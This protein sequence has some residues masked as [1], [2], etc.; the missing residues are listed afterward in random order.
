[1]ENGLSLPFVLHHSLCPIITVRLPARMHV[2][3]IYI[4]HG[5]PELHSQLTKA[6][7]SDFADILCERVC[8]RSDE[9]G[10]TAW[11]DADHT[12]KIKLLFLASLG[13]WEPLRE[14]QGFQAVFG[15]TSRNADFFDRWWSIDRLECDWEADILAKDYASEFDR[16]P[17]CPNPLVKSWLQYYRE[18]GEQSGS[19]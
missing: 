13:Q 7:D 16:M 15:D 4:I 10:R 9:G 5:K 12:L 17:P 11:S 3:A 18:K 2:D 6:V 8:I 19:T 1:M 14:E